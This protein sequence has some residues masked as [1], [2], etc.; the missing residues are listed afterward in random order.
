M[1]SRPSR[2]SPGRSRAFLK[3]LEAAGRAPKTILAYRSDLTGFRRWYEKANNEDLELGRV[4][5]IDV[6]DYRRHLIRMSRRPATINRALAAIRAW[7][8]WGVENDLVSSDVALSVAA[9][10]PVEQTRL[11]PK[12]LEGSELRKFLK[13]LELRGSARDQAIVYLLA[14]AGLRVGELVELRLED[15]ELGPRSGRVRIRAGTAK[16]EIEREVPLSADVRA[17]LK[18]YLE[19]RDEDDHALLFQGERGPLTSSGVRQ[20]IGRYSRAAGVKVTPHKLRHTFARR[21]LAAEKD[22]LGLAE[23]LGHR[24]LETS[25]RYA[26]PSLQDLSEA[27]ERVGVR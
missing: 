13:E 5:G 7:V 24:S 19:D 20:A 17:R 23:L 15:L 1:A 4:A 21:F 9:V 25:R 26:R 16:R 11:A 14:G 10:K 6:Q 3:D 8:A 18:A 12:S 2:R 27:V 22:L